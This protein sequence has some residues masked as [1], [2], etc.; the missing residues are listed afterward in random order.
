MFY[1]I[2]F[3]LE[4]VWNLWRQKHLKFGEMFDNLLYE[5]NT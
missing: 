1:N 2:D 5:R 4:K 3:I